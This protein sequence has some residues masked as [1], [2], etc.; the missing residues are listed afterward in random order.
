MGW[1]FPRPPPG[2]TSLRMSMDTFLA[3]TS[4]LCRAGSSWQATASICR[5]QFC[6]M[7][8]GRRAKGGSGPRLGSQQSP[9]AA[10]R[11][12]LTQLGLGGWRCY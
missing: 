12:P 10:L 4:W 2:P 8:L 11:A 5:Q 1:G 9:V 3:R 7:A 6:T